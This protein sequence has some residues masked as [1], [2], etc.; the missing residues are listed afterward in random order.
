MDWLDECAVTLG[1]QEPVTGKVTASMSQ[2]SAK[3]LY[4]AQGRADKRREKAREA[5][6]RD[7]STLGQNLVGK[8]MAEVRAGVGAPEHTQ[9]IGGMVM[10]YYPAPGYGQ[11]QLVFSGSTVSQVN[12]Y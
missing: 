11:W 12:K 2:A 1:T 6:R 10:W 3:N 4:A 7:R 9:N 5:R 8:S